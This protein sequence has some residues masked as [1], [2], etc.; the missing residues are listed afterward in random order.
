MACYETELDCLPCFALY[1]DPEA[2]AI[3][4]LASRGL[5]LTLYQGMRDTVAVPLKTFPSLTCKVLKSFLLLFTTALNTA[6]VTSNTPAAKW[7]VCL[8]WIGKL[9]SSSTDQKKNI[10]NYDLF[11]IKTKF[12]VCCNTWAQHVA[13]ESRWKVIIMQTEKSEEQFSPGNS[14]RGKTAKRNVYL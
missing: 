4:S 14:D 8:G 5:Y 3:C 1:Q 7:T 11:K 12:R 9:E 10:W 2:S 6:R 13:T